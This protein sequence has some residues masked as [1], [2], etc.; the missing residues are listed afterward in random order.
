MIYIKDDF[1]PKEII[2]Y[3]ENDTSEFKEAKTPGKSFWVKELPKPFIDAVCNKISILEGCDIDNILM[4]VRQAKED[5]DVDWRIHNDSI[6]ENQKPDRAI[7]LYLSKENEEGLN[8][9]AFWSHKDYGDTYNGDGTEEFNRMLTQDANDMSKWKLKTVIGHKQN[10]LI[11]YPCEYF[12]SKYPNEFK[13][14]REVI[15]MFYKTKLNE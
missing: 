2:K 11:S 12:H 6:I 7:V 4:F 3:F 10:R 14:N 8:G 5:Q 9:T 13:N 1:L 15:V